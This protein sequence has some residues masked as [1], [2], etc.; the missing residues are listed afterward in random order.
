VV[1]RLV[2][3]NF[4]QLRDTMIEAGYFTAEDLEGDL[5]RLD[6]PHSLVLTDTLGRVGLPPR[7]SREQQWT[8]SGL[9]TGG[10]IRLVTWRKS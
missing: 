9:Y 10:H 7:R 8:R 6:D 4:C 3:S 5:R 2:R 1:A